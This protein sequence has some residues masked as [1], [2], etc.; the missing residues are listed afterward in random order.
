LPTTR[1][2]SE[3]KHTALVN[4]LLTIR[5]ISDGSI[6][7]PENSPHHLDVI[8]VLADT[9]LAIAGDDKYTPHTADCLIR[10][11]YG[12]CNCLAAMDKHSS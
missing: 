7:L 5:G 9:A 10:A 1:T 4:A 12:I 3:R 8:K 2:T 6:R 11:G